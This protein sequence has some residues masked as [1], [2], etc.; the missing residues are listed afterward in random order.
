MLISLHDLM[1]LNL[2]SAEVSMLCYSSLNKIALSATLILTLGACASKYKDEQNREY[3]GSMQG[4]PR[5]TALSSASEDLR[6]ST[7]FSTLSQNIR[8]GFASAELTPSSRRALNQIAYEI[9]KSEGS[10]TKIRI[11]GVTDPTG[12]PARNQNLSLARAEKV[13]KYLISRGVPENKL[14]AIGKG[15]A[16]SDSATASASQHARDRRVDFLIVE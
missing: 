7:K 14:E 6:R 1:Y 2:A 8:F 5:N 9:K 11:E 13:R 15:P 3:I 16:A 12:D 4:T 10:F